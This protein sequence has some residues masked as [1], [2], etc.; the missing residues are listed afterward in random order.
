MNV[1]K[2]LITAVITACLIAT[3]TMTATAATDPIQDRID[4]V[5]AE[6]GGQQ[7]AW[8]EVSWDDGA[9][10][11]TLAPD[12]GTV[13]PFAVGGCPDSNFC[14][15]SLAG[16]V[17]SRITFTTC[18]SNHP[19]GA[20]GGPVRSIANSRTSGSVTAYNVNAYVLTVPYNNGTNTISTITRLSCS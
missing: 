7:T 13:A 11:L 12:A 4:T 9:T 18:T 5:L 1:V 16:Y 2:P 14:V 17:G 10:I 6:Y 3:T 19:V 15:Y 8:N 20:L